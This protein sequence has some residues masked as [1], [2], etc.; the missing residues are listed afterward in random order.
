M[1]LAHITRGYIPFHPKVFKNTRPNMV[2]VDVGAWNGDSVVYML[3]D[4]PGIEVVA[5]EPHPDI[6]HRLKSNAGLLGRPERIHYINK[7]C[8]RE[9]GYKTLYLSDDGGGGSSIMFLSSTLPFFTSNVH[10]DGIEVEVD[11]LDN[12]LD[13]SGIGTVDLLKIDTEGAEHEVLRGFT[14]Y[15]K[16]TQFHIETHYNLDYV[17]AFLMEKN[18]EYM[19]IG[20]RYYGGAVSIYGIFDHP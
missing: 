16:G 19:D 7:G 15:R 11:T 5:I 14:K 17:L 18:I 20:T 10:K 9:P 1:V 6:F 3:R 2:Y 13:D 4:H 8:W 12:M